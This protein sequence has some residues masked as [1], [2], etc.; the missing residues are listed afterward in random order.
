M[1][2][3]AGALV[4][5]LVAMRLARRPPRG[6]YT[7]GL[8]TGR[9]PLRPG[10]RHHAAAA[11]RLARLRGGAPADRARGGRRRARCWSPRWPGSRST[12]SSPGGPPGR[13]AQPQRRGRLPAHPH[14][15]RRL[16]RHGG[17][18]RW[19]SCATGFDRADPIASLVVVALMVRGRR[20]AGPRQRPDPARGRAGRPGPRRIGRDMVAP[21]RAWSR[22]TTC[23]SG[24]SPPARRRCP[25]T[26]SSRRRCDCHDVRLDLER[27]LRERYGLTHTTLQVDHAQ[28]T[29]HRIGGRLTARGYAVARWPPT[30]VPAHVLV[31]DDDEPI[32]AAVRRALEYE[33]LRV[34]V[35][36]DGY[37]RARRRPGGSRPTSSCST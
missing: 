1:L 10:Q 16:R 22:C 17:G 8:Q 32:A 34:S 37:R 36:G 2:T 19:S 29:L 27:L 20:R 33:G 7:Y 11:R 25:R 15:P 12:W 14:R 5:A 6:G 9:D 23:T 4:L 26:S 31:V 30:S 3:D 21:T 18:R 28:P 24:R 13:P 35:A